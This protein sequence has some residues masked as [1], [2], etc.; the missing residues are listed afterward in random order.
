MKIRRFKN[1]P[2]EDTLMESRSF[3]TTKSNKSL[4]FLR[5]MVQVHYSLIFFKTLLA[6]TNLLCAC[7]MRCN[8]V[9][10]EFSV[11]RCVDGGLK[12]V[13]GI[14]CEAFIKDAKSEEYVEYFYEIL[15][16]KSCDDDGGIIKG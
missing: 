9:D 14:W 11:V 5:E 7:V 8:V 15:M 3:A 6:S 13:D 4:G 10:S 1:L 2:I 12:Q 16:N